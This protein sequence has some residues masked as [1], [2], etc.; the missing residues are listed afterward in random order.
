MAWRADGRTK[1]LYAF[2][3]DDTIRWLLA[4]PIVNFLRRIA[5]VDRKSH[6][7][8]F[9][10]SG[11]RECF[12]HHAVK[13]P[14]DIRLDRIALQH[15]IIHRPAFAVAAPGYDL[16]LDTIFLHVNASG[17]EQAAIGNFTNAVI[18]AAVVKPLPFRRFTGLRPCPRLDGIHVN[19]HGRIVLGGNLAFC[20]LHP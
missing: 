15:A 6:D 10:V 7:R 2:D 11:V 17:E 16:Q 1:A 20:N 8:Q 13:L 14:P 4:H 12:R 5:R 18:L 9:R 3:G 19:F